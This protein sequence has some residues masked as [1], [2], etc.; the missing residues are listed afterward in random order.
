[1]PLDPDQIQTDADLVTSQP[2][3]QDRAGRRDYLRGIATKAAQHP[4][5]DREHHAAV[6]SE[7]W[8]RSDDQGMLGKLADFV[9]RAGKEIAYSLPAAGGAAVLAASDAAGITDSGSGK[10]LARGL[11]DMGDAAV[12][13]AKSLHPNDRQ[14]QRDGA[15]DALKQDL[16]GGLYPDGLEAW[17]A[18]APADQLD[19][20]TKQWVEGLTFGL[21]RKAVAADHMGEPDKEK[22]RQWVESDRSPGRLQDDTGGPGAKAL[23]ADYVVTRDP[24]AWDA[25]KARVSETDSQH[26]TRLQRFANEAELRKV[27]AVGTGGVADNLTTRSAE[28][29]TSPIDIA[30]TVLPFLKGAKAFEAARA[31]SKGAAAMEA[32]K[33][34]AMEAASEG[35]TEALQDPNA[36]TSQVLEAAALGAVG[37][38]MMTG[39]AAGAGAVMNQFASV[40]KGPGGVADSAA[41]GAGSSPATGA[42]VSPTPPGPPAAGS[43]V[44]SYEAGGVEYPAPQ[45]EGAE[46][47]SDA[48]FAAAEKVA[49][50]TG[51]SPASGGESVLSMIAAA[52]AQI[53]PTVAPEAPSAASV[54]SPATSEAA[55]LAPGTLPAP[56]VEAASP[57]ASATLAPGLASVQENN[58]LAAAQ[59]EGKGFT[60]TEVPPQTERGFVQL[61]EEFKG[62]LDHGIELV[63]QGVKDFA[64][65]SVEMIKKFGAA[66]RDYLKDVWAAATKTSEVGA[67]Q[68]GGTVDKSAGDAGGAGRGAT[69]DIEAAREAVTMRNA[70]ESAS[71]ARPLQE[72]F[73][74][75]PQDYTAFTDKDLTARA[76]AVVDQVGSL[77]QLAGLLG[78]VDGVRSLGLDA[79]LQEYVQAEALRRSSAAVSAAT[80]DVDRIRATQTMR[81]L[82]SLW[83]VSGTAAGQQMVARKLAADDLAA[84][85]AVDTAIEKQQK[86]TIDNAVPVEPVTTAVETAATEAGPEATERLVMAITRSD[87]AKLLNTLRKKIAPG[88]DWRDIFTSQKVDQRSWELEVY[89][90]IRLHEALRGLTAGEAVELTREMSKAWQRERRK[91]FNRELTK[92]LTKVAGVK[93]AAVKKIEASAPRLLQLI[94][95]GA[96]DSAAFRDAVAH[97]WG[98]K[99]LASPEAKRLKDLAVQL[100]SAPEG[101]PRRKL[102]QQFI[103]GL[104]SLTNLT[105]LEILDSWWTASVLSG[106][107]TQVDIALGVMNGMED[108]GYGAMVTALRTGNADVAWRALGRMLGN[109]PTAIAEALHHVV[110]GDRSMMR[111]FDAEIKASME[112]G[113]KLMG[114]AGR[115]LMNKHWLGK[116][117][118]AFMEIM[119]RLMTALDH[120][121]STSTYEGAKM[122]AMARHP[123]LYQAAIKIT[124]ADRAAVRARARSELTGGAA[125]RNRTER[126]Q[127]NARVKE[128][129]DSTVPTE[130]IA[131]ATEIGREAALQGDVT[132]LG[133]W[134][135][136]FAQNVGHLFDAPLA[137]MEKDNNGTAWARVTLGALRRASTVSRTITGTKFVRTVGHAVNRRLSYVPGVGLARLAENGMRGAKVDVL[138]AKQLVGTAVTLGIL[139]RL[140]AGDDDKEG[141]E[142]SWKG[143]TPQQKSQLYAEG[144]QPNTIWYRDEKGRVRSFNFNQW[145]LAGILATAGAMEDQRKYHGNTSTPSILING[146]VTG[147]LA[148]TDMAQL[149]G[150]QQVFGDSGYT[151]SANVTD[152][153]VKRLHRYAA[154]NVGGLIPRVAKDVDM[155]LSPELRQA[156]SAWWGV[157]A[158]QVPML[159]EITGGKRVD[160]FG[161]D[162]LLDRGPLSRVTQL[163]SPDPAYRMLGKLNERDLWLPDPSAGQRVVKLPDGTRREMSP[164]EKDRFQRATGEAY[165]TF[166]LEHGEE[167][168]AMKTEDAKSYI[169]R[170][171]KPLRDQAAYK[172]THR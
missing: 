12:Q 155:V 63:R 116:A 139:S 84:P 134:I 67:V 30:T 11:A 159:R 28:F 2:G 94:N 60:N 152:S 146:I 75:A 49:T 124:D 138:L 89:R 163:G 143:L 39:G 151:T 24:G 9:G 77:D 48:D 157:W 128:I 62:A 86:T 73:G 36:P 64:A 74:G 171:T 131:E 69:M 29:Q 54:E 107:R 18:G 35:A 114:N 98:I 168:L 20:E 47:A 15:L 106:W 27:Q 90:R 113:H 137:A 122:M 16:D 92:Q 26:T 120:V 111:N 59:T 101:L 25:F 55:P 45:A 13:R 172:A 140:G 164:V 147:S 68:L 103:E 7:L 8:K 44:G 19:D 32:L 17:M 79:A 38:G 78:S 162:I 37:A 99:S 58:E 42:N 82:K 153:F 76:S 129:L 158:Q 141:I 88:M 6:M 72:Q 156:P 3:W 161:K 112:D 51:P 96:F 150:L 136:K 142:G 170:V 126:L 41:A 61:P 53:A 83:D 52:S 165:R 135:W 160:I 125:P 133:W 154:T 123:E 119:G 149:Q 127:E 148:F 132:G 87:D 130:I 118:G 70:P 5:Y 22:V 117:P 33:G 56:A 57:K 110:T 50:A 105:K 115:Q 85:M 108:V 80:N 40:N 91:V 23:L 166:I 71:R 10:R 144:K 34:V 102:A 167:M 65:W 66:I 46:G 104:Q 4:E 169:R 43:A 97:E 145:G 109:L 95:L 81:R 100:Q 93:P 121:N 31:G 14:E 21:G 1:M